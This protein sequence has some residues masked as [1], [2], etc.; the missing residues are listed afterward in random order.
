MNLFQRP[1]TK[2]PRQATACYGNV[3]VLALLRM[4]RGHG[5]KNKNLEA[6]ILGGARPPEAT[7]E[8]I[9][10]ENCQIA[11][12]VLFRERIAIVSEDTGGRRGRKVVFRTDTSELMVMKVAQL[13][14]SD[15]YPYPKG[16]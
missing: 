15:W 14:Q 7:G 11:R 16:R 3:A 13:R 2:D 5:S 10:R 8:D 4:L 9:S 1:F 6:Q 12:K